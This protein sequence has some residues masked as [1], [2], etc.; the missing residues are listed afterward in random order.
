MDDAS[1][2]DV[3]KDAKQN[4]NRMPFG[5]NGFGQKEREEFGRNV[6]LA[7]SCIEGTPPHTPLK[8]KG[9]AIPLDEPSIR[10]RL[11][12]LSQEIT[13]SHAD[14]LELLVRFD[15]LEGWKKTGASHCAAWMNAE[16][17]IGLRSGWEY[18]RVGR[19]L[20]TL[21]TLRSLFRVGS[22]SW[23]KVRLISR[24]A[25]EDN[26]KILCHA[27]LDA[28]V[29]DLERICQAYRWQEDSHSESEN[30]RAI[31]QWES[32]SFTWDKASNGSTRIQLTLP[33]QI[34][35]A[36]LN[37]VEH[38]MNQLDA[39]E[40]KLSQ[41]RADAAV[42][43]AEKSLQA[44]GREIAT[45]DRYQVI[46]SID[47]SELSPNNNTPKKRPTV[48][49]A[50]PI[51]SDT[52]K[53]IA[54][55]CSLSTIE[56]INGEPINIGRK[57]RIWPPAM[58]RAIKARDQQCVWPGCTQS[59]HLH[60]H[61]IKHWADGGETSVSNG[62]SLCSHHHTLVHEGGYS[63]EK[64]D[65]D[66]TRLHEQFTHQQ[67]ADDSSLFEFERELRND[68]DS[69]NRVRKL[70][71]S[72][73]RFRVTDAQGRDIREQSC[74]GIDDGDH[75][76]Q[77]KTRPQERTRVHCSEALSYYQCDVK[78]AANAESFTFEAPAYYAAYARV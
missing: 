55:D 74:K 69:F 26:E 44:A 9:N 52:A 36:F 4:T 40:H 41:R 25:D 10:L 12:A 3:G 38:A 7:M 54:C 53:R 35:Q 46:V 56:T 37:S 45:A 68:K 34:A 49:G 30:N 17:G 66:S 27:A 70:S 65:D 75:N 51:A 18:L 71:P 73:Y 5:M 14:L 60:I 23:S 1:K 39:S 62:A 42:W 16:I 61:H 19:K 57:S 48:H 13:S 77:A 22:L 58:A 20:R 64:V 67:R 63:I 78:R 8:N 50:G 47:N 2:P 31:Q 59:H 24:V 6:R 32:R 43:M 33:P 28:S 21:K 15:D 11:K 29:S 72:H 76:N